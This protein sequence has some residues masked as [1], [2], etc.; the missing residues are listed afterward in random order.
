MYTMR[1]S[2]EVFYYFFETFHAGK[3]DEKH[4]HIRYGEIGTEVKGYLLRLYLRF[5]NDI[6]IEARF[7]AYS[8]VAV[9]AACE[10]ICRWAEDKTLYEANQLNRDQIQAA[11]NLSSLEFHVVLLIERLWKK[12]IE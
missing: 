7:Q 3:L 10:Y 6:I 8:S 11:L 1:Y 9:I 4:P 12:T 2:K 5:Q